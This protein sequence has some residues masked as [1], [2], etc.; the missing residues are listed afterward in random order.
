[1]TADWAN[2]PWLV[3]DT[4]TTGVQVFEDRIVEVAAVTL[5][6]DGTVR[7]SYAAIIDPGIEIPDSAAAVHG[8]TTERARTEGQPPAVVLAEVAELVRGAQDLDVPLCIYNA[9]FDWPLLLAEAERHGVDFPAA[10]PIVD[11]FLIDRLV[12]RFRKGKRQLGM[13]AEHYGV[14]LGD[15]AHGAEADAVAVGQVMREIVRR[16]PEVG[17]RSLA[18]LVLWQTLGAEQD[19]QNFA[20]YM[21][22]N[23]DP[24]FES[25]PGWPI[26]VAVAS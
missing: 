6:V 11:P 1:M 17:E 2:A 8:I 26:P 16:Y 22:R 4:E 7:S 24:E 10:A 12:D 13:V 20:D 15:K 25:V 14:A 19:R 9:K 5:A 21:R 18:S 3:V 23:V